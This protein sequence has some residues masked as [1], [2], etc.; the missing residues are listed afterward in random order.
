MSESSPESKQGLVSP[1]SV[2]YEYGKNFIS[3]LERWRLYRY[4]EE[5]AD[6]YSEAL[7]RLSQGSINRLLDIGT[8]DGKEFAT[9]A[10]KLGMQ[11][12][13]Y[14]IDPVPDAYQIKAKFSIKPEITFVQAKSEDL[15]FATDSMDGL[16]AMFT[17]YHFDPIEKAFMEMKRVVKPGG[18]LAISTSGKLNKSQHRAFESQIAEFTDL[19][20]API[21]TESF[22]LD[23]AA[24]ILPQWFEVEM[25]V[26][27]RTR[28]LITPGDALEDYMA[29]L[30]SVA[31]TIGQPQT[32]DQSSYIRRQWR[33]GIEAVAIPQIESELD[34]NG[35]F[36]DQIERGLFI[37]RNVR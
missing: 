33:E 18:L 27:Q 30:L 14:G 11:A 12:D 9:A 16:L 29:S 25:F 26:S 4:A 5:P 10:E 20:K 37:C 22:D 23:A 6:F 2:K 1:E 35:V 28:M 8:Y 7:R 19:P 32:R 24:K 15:P 34:E 17:A 31:S 21:F 13:L 3:L 36:V